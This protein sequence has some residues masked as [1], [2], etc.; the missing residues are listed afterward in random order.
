MKQVQLTI[1]ILLLACVAIADDIVSILP[2][3]SPGGGIT[4]VVTT[5]SGNMITVLNGTI[6]IDAT[7]ATFHGSRRDNATIADVKPGA[8]IIAAIKNAD[9]APGTTLQA[10]NIVILDSPAAS[11]TGRVQAVDLVGNSLTMFGVRIQVTAGTRINALKRD[12]TGKLADIKVGDTAAVE[13]NVAGSG[14]VA[15]S[16]IVFAPIP[17][18]SLE[19]TVKSIGAT[20]WLITTAKNG[21]VSVTVNSDTRIDPGA[22]VGD[23]VR[24]FGTAD[25]AGHITA[26]SIS[27]VNLTVRPPA[28]APLQGV[29]KSIA[30]TSWVITTKEGKDVTVAITSETKFESSIKVGDNVRVLTRTDSAGNLIALLIVK[31]ETSKHRAA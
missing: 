11:L 7:G 2:M 30:S 1:A 9:A 22:K 3:P 12:A 14:L 17:N 20:S 13:V 31:A 23:T 19:G 18:A 25:G 8:R 5:V 24:I 26:T 21:D 6:A 16:I 4:A 29:V 27:V 28:E 15:E 10:A